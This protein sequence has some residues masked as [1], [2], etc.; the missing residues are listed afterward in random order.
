MLA[1]Q[2][3]LLTALVSVA[4][5]LVSF[6]AVVVI[7]VE[8][9]DSDAADDGPQRV[10]FTVPGVPGDRAEALRRGLLGDRPLLGVSVERRDGGLVVTQ[11]VPESPAARAGVRPGDVLLRVNDTAVTDLASLQRAVDAVE[12]GQTYTLQLRR[13]GKEEALRV[14]RPRAIEGFGVAPGREFRFDFGTAP[15]R[16]VPADPELQRL[17]QELQ[18][19]LRRY[20]EQQQRPAPPAPP[21]APRS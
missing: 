16:A 4:A 20:R 15:G 8:V 14:E 17:F 3:N 1:W 12:P 19:A 9:R 10:E 5:L 6:A 11:V 2:R 21:A 18:D 7:V 13:D